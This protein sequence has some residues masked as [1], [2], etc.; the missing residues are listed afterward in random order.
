MGQYPAVVFPDAVAIAVEFLNDNL[1]AL[2]ATATAY[3]A[4]PSPRPDEF[5]TVRRTGGPALGKVWDAAQ[6]TFESWSTTTE[7]ASDLA[8]IVRAAMRTATGEVVSSTAIGRVQEASGPADLPDPLS[9]QSRFSQ[10][11]VVNLR[12]DT[13]T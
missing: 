3:D 9:D 2:G 11:F 4:P 6:L 5:V 7:G 10:T 8:Q 13:P 1:S 12:G